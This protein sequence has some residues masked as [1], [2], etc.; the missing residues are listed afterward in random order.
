[1]A[2]LAGIA[3]LGSEAFL[4]VR[5]VVAIFAL[6]CGW[7]AIQARHWWWLPLLGVVAVLWNPVYPFA[8]S[9]T[10]WQSAQF[11]AAV[12]FLLVGAFVKVRVA[13]DRNG[14]RESTARR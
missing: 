11:A 12:L 1:M 4:V 10:W 6:I 7:F 14:A 9:G 3:L 5:F 8:F 2:L 13:D